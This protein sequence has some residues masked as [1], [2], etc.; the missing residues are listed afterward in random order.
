MVLGSLTGTLDGAL[1]R[2]NCE[3]ERSTLDIPLSWRALRA[4]WRT[5]HRVRADSRLGHTVCLRIAKLRL[6]RVR[7]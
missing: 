2:V 1:V 5:R 3:G 4:L 7:L 6:A